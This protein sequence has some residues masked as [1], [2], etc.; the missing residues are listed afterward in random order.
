[1]HQVFAN[2]MIPHLV[3][4]IKAGWSSF[5]LELFCYTHKRRESQTQG[6]SWFWSLEILQ[7]QLVMLLYCGRKFVA[8]LWQEV[9]CCAVPVDDGTC[10]VLDEPHMV[11][12]ASATEAPQVYYV[13]RRHI[14]VF[15]H[16]VQGR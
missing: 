3:Q 7:L 4:V 6:D 14:F 13:G 9:C 1:M 2:C 15:V 12:Y 11:W 5:V 16:L 8:V 10:V